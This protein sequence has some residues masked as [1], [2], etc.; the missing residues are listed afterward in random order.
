MKNVLFYISGHGYGHAVRTKEVIRA[1]LKLREDVH[2]TIRTHAPAWIF[3]DL[4]NN[5]NVWITD[6]VL[7]P[8][9]CEDD[10]LHINYEKTVQKLSDFL[11]TSLGLVY[12]E[13]AYC[14][15]N[16]I[17]LIIS[18]I[19]SIAGEIAARLGI[20]CLAMS[21]FLWDWIYE[22]MIMDEEE[23]NAMLLSIR[24]GYSKMAHWIRYPFY[25]QSS[26]LE[27]ISDVSLVIQNEVKPLEVLKSELNIPS[28]KKVIYIAFRGGLDSR[29]ISRAAENSGDY[30]FILA[31]SDDY[32]FPKNVYKIS[33]YPRF[34]FTE[35]INF[36]D[37]IVGKPG[38]GLVSTCVGFKKP[39]LYP[40][41][42]GFRE[43]EVLVPAIPNYI[44]AIEIPHEDFFAGRWKEYLD[45]L[46]I[47]PVPEKSIR[48]DG[49]KESAQ[50]INEY[51]G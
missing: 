42:Y 24:T 7:D 11:K 21:N 46:S 41:R 49:A 35:V 18:D 10:P 23:Q 12:H 38:Y 33:L 25:H 50:I 5:S 43:D 16:D 6:A 20:P 4:N 28:D 37:I 3:G 19:P 9:V 32:A 48:T 1:L 36:A 30:I 44:P 17:N 14:M 34:S 13:T 40:R 31:D 27:K 26:M 8:G 51:L 47:M 29:T 22:P 2:V 45:K 15:Q 39:L